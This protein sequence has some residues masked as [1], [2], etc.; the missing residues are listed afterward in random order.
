MRICRSARGGA[1]PRRQPPA[2]AAPTAAAVTS[3]QVFARLRGIVLGDVE[4]NTR[5]GRT[6]TLPRISIPEKAMVVPAGPGAGPGGGPAPVHSA[7]GARVGPRWRHFSPFPHK[8]GVAKPR[9]SWF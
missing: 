8:P 4:S 5:E 2:A 9:R 6:L 1:G 7:T 3:R